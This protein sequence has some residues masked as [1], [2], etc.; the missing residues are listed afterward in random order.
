MHS[1]RG[2]PGVDR[3]V[4][5]WAEKRT[6]RPERGIQDWPKEREKTQRRW[7]FP[8]CQKFLTFWFYLTPATTPLHFP[9]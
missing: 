5:I 9:I 1:G 3:Y 7:V 4:E 6:G 8:F 2:I